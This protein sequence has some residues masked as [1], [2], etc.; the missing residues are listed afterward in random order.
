MKKII[1]DVVIEK[2]PNIKQFDNDPYNY[3]YYNSDVSKN[4]NHILNIKQYYIGNKPYTFKFHI[5]SNK[6]YDKLKSTLISSSKTLEWTHFA[7]EY[8]SEK[9]LLILDNLNK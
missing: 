1:Y 4:N 7:D 8:Q 5:D 3:Y 2:I 9:A 6:H